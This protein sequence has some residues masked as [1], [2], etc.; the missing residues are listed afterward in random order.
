MNRVVSPLSLAAVLAGALVPAPAR[1]QP[2]A[3][4]PEATPAAIEAAT[5]GPTAAPR[6]SAGEG[7]RTAPVPEAPPVFAPWPTA[8]L[9]LDLAI[10]TH[11]RQVMRDGADLSEIR[12]DRAELGGRIALGPRAAAELRLETVRS[13]VE[14][15]A[16]GVDGDSIVARLRFAQLVGETTLG[17]IRL[18]GALG[19]VPDPWIRT[20]ED[21]YT[22]RPLSRSASERLLGWAPADL[23][24][25]GKVTVGP[26]RLTVAL[27]NGE[28]LRYPE[29][30]TGKTT[31][32]VLEVVPLARP[33][34][35]LALAAVVRDGSLGV[36]SLRERRAGGGA[37]LTTPWVRAGAELVQ[38]W[39]LGE[40]AEL[41]GLAL[42][43]WVDAQV[44]PR[45]VIAARGA[46]L[47]L[48]TGGRQSTVGGAIAIEPW[49]APPASPRGRLRLWLAL[50]RI[51]SSGD[52]MPVAGAEPGDATLVM[53]IASAD[54]P[55]TLTQ[56]P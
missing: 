37:S 20:V 24:A 51:T 40:R 6:P 4:P 29:R 1:A 34:A 35:R 3:A 52:A 41:E 25:V 47:G 56:D 19:L 21:G 2:E 18:E 8:P 36:A 39:G 31:T 55:F 38:A 15:G 45:V 9:V 22:L 46:T 7:V 12:L 43:G 23:S 50:D 17:G 32:A 26:A 28:G 54:A 30:N 16:L 33:T 13:A 53:L 42:G 5:S 49:L 11:A 14:G 44:L 10:Y 27:G 48:A